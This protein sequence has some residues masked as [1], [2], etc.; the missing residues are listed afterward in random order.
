MDRI[1]YRGVDDTAGG[2]RECEG[3]RCGRAPVP[4]Q[5]LREAETKIDLG[6]PGSIVAC[7]S[8]KEALGT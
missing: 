2:Q 3:L 4:T 5:R 7:R 8:R 1:L 6:P